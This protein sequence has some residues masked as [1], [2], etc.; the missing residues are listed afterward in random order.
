M[1]FLV[2]ELALKNLRRNT[3]RNLI[4]SVAIIA[5]VFSLIIGFGLVDGI[6]ENTIRAQEDHLAGH[7]LLRPTGYPEDNRNF[8]LDQTKSPPESLD[9]HPEIVDYA[10]RLFTRVRL[11]H[12][13]QSLRIKLLAHDLEREDRVFI[14]DNWSVEGNWPSGPAEIGLGSGLAGLLELQVGDVIILEGRTKPGAINAQQ[15][16]VTSIVRTQNASLDAF[17]AWL[18][19]ENANTLLFFDTARSHIALKIKGG[20]SAAHAFADNFE[21]AV[22]SAF[23][24]ESEVADLI[25]I[26]RFRRKAI[27]FISVIL[28][29]IAATGIANTIIMATYERIPEVGT[30]RAMG[31]Q[32]RDVQ[33]MFLL[34]GTIMG[35][36]A[37]ICGGLLG[38]A[39]NYYLSYTGIDLSSKADTFGEV[40]I[41]TVIYTAFSI[42]QILWAIS[43][44]LIVALLASIWPAQHAVS[45]HPADAVRRH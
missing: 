3:K 9:N 2:F 31:M 45:I 5:A 24:A 26:N 23:P 28:M 42:S 35:L 27:S 32:N 21:D 29:A 22:W 12:K 4:S 17:C 10:D 41:P 36:L 11:I 33:L 43:F 38:G 30:V 40:P 14:K 1:V 37:G 25:A 15:Y 44:G 34:E 20:R 6:D 16:T 13:A 39:L 7:V 18:P 8:P 19:M